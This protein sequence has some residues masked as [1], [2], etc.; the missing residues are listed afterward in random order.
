MQENPWKMYVITR[1]T[2]E[3]LAALG[4]Q[5]Y[6]QQFYL[7][8]GTAL[9]LHLGHRKSVDLD[10]F[11]ENPFDEDRLLN[12]LQVLPSFALVARDAQTLHCHVQGVKVSFIGYAYPLLA[13]L[14][15]LAGVSVADPIDIACMKI[16]AISSRGTRRDFVDLYALARKQGLETLLAAFERKFANTR[17]NLVHVLKSL[18]YFSDAEKDPMPDMV[19]QISWNEVTQ[20]F[21]AKVPEIDIS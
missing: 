15:K 4:P 5:D 11:T 14:G 1:E 6:V 10:F 12:R 2:G 20:F 13:P 8:G 19:A 18:V 7:A 16:S 21:L 3:V 17:F 9:A